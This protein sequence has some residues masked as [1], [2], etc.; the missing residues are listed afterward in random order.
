MCIRDRS[1]A[2]LPATIGMFAGKTVD[3]SLIHIST[4]PAHKT[5]ADGKKVRV[6]KK[7]GAEI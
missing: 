6:C 5:L 3:L 1:I 4:R 7:C 2:A